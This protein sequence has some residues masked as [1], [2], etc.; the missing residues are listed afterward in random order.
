MLPQKMISSLTVMLFLTQSLFA[1][2][3]PVKVTIED[4]IQTALKNNPRTQANALRLEAAF[5][6]LKAQKQYAYLPTASVGYSK[7][8]GSS[9]SSSIDF[10]LRMNLFNGFADY[11]AIKAGECN[12]KRLEATYKSTNSFIQN[13][14]GKIVGSVIDNYI[15]LISVRQSLSTHE[16]TLERLKMLLPFA[17]NIEQQTTIESQIN[18][19]Q[20]SMQQHASALKIAEGNYKFIVNSDV[21]QLTDTFDEVISKIEI[22]Q[23]EA[24]A[25]EISLLKSPE[26]L[27]AKLALE[28]DRLSR[29][30]ER[31][32]LYSARIDLSLNQN[33]DLGGSSSK[34]NSAQIVL[35]LPFSLGQQTSYNAGAKNIQATELDLNGTID[36]I[37]NNLAKDYINLQSQLETANSYDTIYNSNEIKINTMLQNLPKLT[38]LEL[39]V[40]V[41]LITNQRYQFETIS[42]TKQRISNIKYSVQRNIGTLFETN[43]FFKPVL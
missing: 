18:T 34:S 24:E 12:Y 8:L 33:K 5:E 41:T 29:K 31:A 22:P 3:N 21:P 4:S 28:C 25:F 2:S 23:N 35:N 40:L 1:Q 37:K 17:K 11:Y 7:D 9:N 39:N 36:E 6:R 20:I 10:N 43:R 14:S 13:T 42:Y 38:L 16:E 26:I 15:E 19:I 30:A 32:N 27:E